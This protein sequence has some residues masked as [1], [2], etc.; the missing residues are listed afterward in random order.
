MRELEYPFDAGYLLKKSKR[1]KRT[2]LEQTAADGTPVTFLKKRIAV[3]GGSTTHDI[4]RMLELFLLNY[5]IE[6]EFY[7]SEYAQYWQDAMFDNEELVQFH[8]DLIYIHTTGRNITFFPDMEDSLQGIEDKL[9]AQMSHFR[10]MWEKLENTYHCPVIQNNFEFPFYRILG[11]RD[12]YDP[13]GKTAFIQRLNMEFARYAAQ[14]E[15]FYIYDIQYES[16]A[17]GLD[18]WTDPSYWHMYKYAM[19]MQAIPD[20][21]FH[22]SHIIKAVFGKNKKAFVLDLDNT[23]WGGIVGDDGPENLE[24]GQETSMGQVYQEFQGYLKEHKKIGVLL[25]VD[26]KNEQENA[27]AGLKHPE[28]ILKPE[29]FIV[30]K[31]NWLPKSQNLIEIASELNIGRDALVFVDDN[32]AEREIIRQHVPET[33]VPEMTDGDQVNPDQFIRILD[34]NAYFEVVTLSEDDKHRNEMYKANA[35]RKE[36]EESFGNYSDFLKSLEMEAV[37]R[38]FEPVYYSRIAQLTN[39]SNQFNLT[40]K[41]MTQAEVEQMAQDPGYITLYGK[42]KDKFGDNGVVSLVIGKKNGDTLELILWLMSCRVLKR[43]M[44]Q[45]MLDTL[46]WQSRESGIRKLHGYY[47][48]TAKNAMVKDFYGAMGFQ[49]LSEKEGDSEWEYVIPEKYENKN[50]VIDVNC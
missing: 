33:A 30:I 31:A 19:S 18:R 45:A 9:E 47:Y 23:L 26:S 24:I 4:I 13:H 49:K 42:L 6:P 39:K 21:A 10:V 17:F 2:L 3:L 14:Q 38:G 12:G 29:D 46:V 27:L 22:L 16:A 43:D 37:I 8:P 36:Q 32:P 15:H 44:E 35:M 20:F 40:T 5:G 50:L 25:N 1:I 11:N 34:K 7:E 41:R 48:K 28:G